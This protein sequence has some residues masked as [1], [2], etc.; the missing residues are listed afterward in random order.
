MSEGLPRYSADGKWWWDGEQWRPVERSIAFTPYNPLEPQGVRRWRRKVLLVGVTLFLVAAAAV[1]ATAIRPGG[2]RI[3]LPRPVS[4]HRAPSPSA[5]PTPTL[6]AAQQAAAHY[7]VVS[8][9]GGGQVKQR[10]ATAI[11]S[12]TAPANLAVCRAS[13][14]ALQ[15]TESALAGRLAAGTVPS[16]LA[17]PDGRQRTALG[18]MDRGARQAVSGIDQQDPGQIVVGM[19]AVKQAEQDREAAQRQADV[20]VC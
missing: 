16:C 6:S 5:R 7:R 11:K 18:A 20:A 17:G 10:T 4:T 19:A 13:L 15:G 2:A 12:C 9:R 8:D 1:L 14:V 3:P